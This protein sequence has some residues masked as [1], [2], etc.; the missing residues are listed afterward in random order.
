MLFGA[1]LGLLLIIAVFISV[2]WFPGIGE[3][4]G[5]HK[6]LT[7]A[8]LYT[9]FAFGVFGYVFQRWRHQNPPV[10]WASLG[11]FFLVHSLLVFLYSLYVSPMR[12]WQWMILLY[13][14]GYLGAFF[15]GWSTSKFGRPGRRTSSRSLKS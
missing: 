1:F 14:D 7:D 11:V 3:H 4:L 9:V 2:I 13:V 8:V 6:T 12:G 10:F 15:I 5:R